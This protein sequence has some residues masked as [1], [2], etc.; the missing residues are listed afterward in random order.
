VS[1][2]TYRKCQACGDIHEVSAWPRECLEQFKRKRSELPAPFIR[3]DVMDALMNHANGLMYDSR[4]A[5]ERGVRDAGCEIVGSE[6]IEPKARPVLSDRELK[7]DIKTA[8]DQVE[9]RL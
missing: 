3:S 4:S 1:R 9:A 2:N 8:M 6:K 5:Y 7:Q